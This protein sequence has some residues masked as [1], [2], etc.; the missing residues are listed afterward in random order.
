MSSTKT[1]EEAKMS[2]VQT[3]K[4]AKSENSATFCPFPQDVQFN[5]QD[6]EERVILLIRQDWAA[7]LSQ[8][9]MVLL[10]LLS[11]ILFVVFGRSITFITG[12]IITGVSIICIL[13][14]FTIVVDSILKWYFS[15][16]IITT[17][18]VVD[19]DFKSVMNHRSSETQ[20]ERIQDVTHSVPGVL[21]SV[22]DFGNVFIQTAGKRSEFEFLHVPKPRDIQDVL[23][24]LLELK[25]NGD[26]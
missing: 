9:L 1:P 18:K 15:V 22:L 21:G 3:L 19:I 13:L 24:D 17:Q 8:A 26:I 4:A 2:F 7:Y 25:Q 12:Q 5:G 10:L 16:N 11:P 14:A 20:L 6:S 23:L